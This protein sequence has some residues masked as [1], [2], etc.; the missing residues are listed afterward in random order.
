MLDSG[1]NCELFYICS[2]NTHN[3][4]DMEFFFSKFK[5]FLKKFKFQ[6]SFT[7]CKWGVMWMTYKK[8]L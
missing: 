4:K 1:E 8:K 3:S 5:V 7:T 6:K 2:K